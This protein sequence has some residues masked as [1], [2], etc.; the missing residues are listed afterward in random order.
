MGRGTVW[1]TGWDKGG[2]WGDIGC[3]AGGNGGTLW[4]SES[5]ESR[6]QISP[7]VYLLIISISTFSARAHATC[8]AWHRIPSTALPSLL[9]TH[10]VND[11]SINPTTIRSFLC[12]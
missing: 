4:H 8:L 7:H 12:M 10:R 9:H 5:T 6:F 2:V 3:F 11:N 1:G